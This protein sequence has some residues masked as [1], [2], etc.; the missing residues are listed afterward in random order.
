MANNSNVTG[1]VYGEVIAPFVWV[2]DVQVQKVF[3]EVISQLQVVAPPSPPARRRMVSACVIS[4]TGGT[5]SSPPPPPPPPS[6]SPPSTPP[7]PPS[8]ASIPALAVQPGYQLI[9]SWATYENNSDMI[10][11][12]VY[13]EGN[14][15]NLLDGGMVMNGSQ[16]SYCNTHFAPL[17]HIHIGM[18]F[19]PQVND[20]SV[21]NSS[22][23]HTLQGGETNA[24]CQIGLGLAPGG[25]LEVFFGTN[26][27]GLGGTTLG[28]GTTA[29]A[30][31]TAYWL[32][33]DIVYSTTVGS[34]T[35]KIGTNT[36]LAFSNICTVNTSYGWAER[37]S[38]AAGAG[39]QYLF[40]GM[41]IADGSVGWTGPVNIS[42][43]L[44]ASDLA[45]NEF[46][47]SV[48]SNNHSILNT[49]YN[50]TQYVSASAPG[51]TDLY[52]LTVPTPNSVVAV[53]V[54][55]EA[56]QNGALVQGLV[57]II[58]DGTN[59]VM[60]GSR[61][62][63]SSLPATWY[64]EVRGMFPQGPDSQAWTPAKL[65]NLQV[66][67]R[68]SPF[69]QGFNFRA[70]AAFVTDRASC[71]YVLNDQY[72]TTRDGVT[73][74]WNTLGTNV[75][76]YDRQTG[77]GDIPAGI[78]CQINN[79]S[80]KTFSIDVPHPG[81]YEFRI[82]LGDIAAQSRY[83][84]IVSDGATPLFTLDTNTL[85]ANQFT[86]GDAL[87]LDAAFE[88]GYSEGGWEEYNESR[89]INLTGTKLNVLIGSPTNT[90]DGLYTCLQHIDLIYLDEQP[91]AAASTPV[92]VTG[93][94]VEAITT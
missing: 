79:G 41:Y 8:S 68:V 32:E 49:L 2:P 84:A 63:A 14:G 58:S 9:E 74:G 90:N 40:G 78:N 12:W 72:P 71:T 48:G 4:G 16:V 53:Q 85:A 7:P 92:Q 47:P 89:V 52:G 83:Y 51:S 29:L 55:A 28:T 37:L 81:R 76:V 35:L 43:L 93:L 21:T 56:L 65:E 94:F 62:L 66:G 13:Q 1:K 64:T 11:R 36:E 70:T 34:V 46:T 54:R 25:F 42:R 30:M 80:Q 18:W 10:R 6:G 33:L 88:V 31:G 69:V 24:N 91:L 67:M 75:V 45:G 20:T 27:S 61:V 57:P 38:L 5:G 50:Y 60:R 17:S 15:G 39:S 22:F 23:L 86:P 26:F 44:L 77:Y 82:L 19:T 87:G 73:F 59:T 3:L